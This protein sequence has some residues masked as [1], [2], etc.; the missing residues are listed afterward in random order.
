MLNL[1]L[2]FLEK[3]FGFKVTAFQSVEKKSTPQKVQIKYDVNSISSAI[4][5]KINSNEMNSTLSKLG[6]G[7][8]N[9]TNGMCEVPYYRFGDIAYINDIV[10]EI[11]RFKDLDNTGYDAS[12]IHLPEFKNQENARR[13][14]EQKLKG[15]LLACGMYEVITWSFISEHVNHLFGNANPIKIINPINKEFET[16]RGTIVASIMQM[17]KKNV[18]RDVKD[19]VIFECGK[20]LSK[21]FPNK[22]RKMFTG[23]RMG[24]KN[25]DNIHDM[26]R[27]YD[28]F[29]VR[30]DLIAMVSSV[31][32]SAHHTIKDHNMSHY[33]YDLTPKFVPEYYHPYLS[34]SIRYDGEILGCCGTIHP[35]LLKQDNLEVPIYTFEMFF[36]TVEQFWDKKTGKIGVFSEFQET[37]RDMSFGVKQEMSSDYFVNNLI[38]FCNNFQEVKEVKLFDIYQ[39][40]SESRKYFGVRFKLQKDYGTLTNGEIESIYSKIIGVCYAKVFS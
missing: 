27:K 35:K 5:V 28:F 26:Q 10:E 31:I 36:D 2:R 37:T 13:V 12:A 3:E 23:L 21:D 14:L 33:L 8:L 11:V 1:F 18:A 7:I 4:G 15:T 34:T 6:F 40:S 16:M 9:E 29:D 22:Q 32:K 19:M 38:L 24:S 20:V 25:T 30:D 17:V 39:T